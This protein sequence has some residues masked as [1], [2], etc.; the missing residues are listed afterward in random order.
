[1]P[2]SVYV[3]SSGNKVEI[4]ACPTALHNLIDTNISSAT[5][6]DMLVY[7]GFVWKNEGRVITLTGNTTYINGT[8]NEIHYV[9]QGNCVIVSGRFSITTEK[10]SGQYALFENLPL[11]KAKTGVGH[12][13]AVTDS[14]NKSFIINDNGYLTSNNAIPIGNYNIACSYICE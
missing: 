14:G 4:G 8:A 9:K 10:P 5:T 12:I 3:D 1:M 11:P 13:A 7:D 6:G 2:K